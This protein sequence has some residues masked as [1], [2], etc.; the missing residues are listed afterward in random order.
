[1]WTEIIIPREDLA[2]L[3][4]QAFP[5]TIRLGDADSD[6]SLALSDL[7]DVRLVPDRGLRVECKAR[8]RWPVLGIEIPVALNA[9]TLLLV[10]S[11]GRGPDGDTLVFRIV[12]EHADFA[13]V[14]ELLDKRIT[15][16]INSKL[17]AKDAELSWDLSRTLTLSTPLPELLEELEAFALR[18]RWAKVRITDEAVVYA[19]SF[20]TALVRTGSQV[21][22]ELALSADD[23]LVS[24][25]RFSERPVTHRPTAR[26]RSVKSLASAGIFGIGAG[27]AYVALRRALRGRW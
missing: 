5:L 20:N 13:A 2:R 24:P 14:P 19:I 23:E 17:A 18:P 21:P 16:T 1:M 8:V 22:A 7:K 12:L 4:G 11:I 9:L 10:P 25:V 27:A 26:E 15:S 6:N 3:L